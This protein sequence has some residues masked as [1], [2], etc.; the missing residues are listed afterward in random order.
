LT[1]ETAFKLA[2]AQLNTRTVYLNDQWH[3]VGKSEINNDLTLNWALAP[4]L[5]Q[6]NHH[7]DAKTV[8]HDDCDKFAIQVEKKHAKGEQLFI[9][10]G[11][12]P[13]WFL[14]L[15]YG[16][17]IGNLGTSKFVIL[18]IFLGNSNPHNLIEFTNTTVLRDPI[19]KKMAIE[20]GCGDGHAISLQGASWSILRALH[21]IIM[22]S[23]VEKVVYEQFDKWPNS[24]QNLVL[25]ELGKVVQFERKK[26]VKISEQIKNSVLKQYYCNQIDLLDQFKK[27]YLE[28]K[29]IAEI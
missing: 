17:I 19:T 26:F 5:D 4:F 10:Y 15:E 24:D 3:D 2:W 11:E 6:F 22:G 20:L 21:L 14:L 7:Y 9:S 13:D 12:H 28:K 29:I 25:N 8:I 18:T 16:F 27:I 23:W 1:C